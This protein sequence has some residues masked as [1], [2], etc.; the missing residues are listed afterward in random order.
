[1]VSSEKNPKEVDF[2]KPD[3]QNIPL[4]FYRDFP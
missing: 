4:S 2:F 3:Y 1:M